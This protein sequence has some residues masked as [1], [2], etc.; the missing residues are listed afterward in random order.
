MRTMKCTANHHV[1]NQTLE[2]NVHCDREKDV[3]LPPTG[4]CLGACAI[5]WR[6]WR[7]LWIPLVGEVEGVAKNIMISAWF[8]L[9]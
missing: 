1:T 2:E 5:T 7:R 6:Q 8:C 3:I 9:R 4:C